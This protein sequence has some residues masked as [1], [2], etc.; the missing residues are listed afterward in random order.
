MNSIPYHVS[1][2]PTA[3]DNVSVHFQN[4]FPSKIKYAGE[5]SMLFFMQFYL[6]LLQMKCA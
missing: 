1:F 5:P 4:E 2:K 3:Y 6:V